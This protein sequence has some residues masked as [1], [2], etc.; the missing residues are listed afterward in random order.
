MDWS[1]TL[2]SV[3]TCFGRFWQ[4]DFN[5]D[6]QPRTGSSSDVNEDALSSLRINEVPARRVY[7]PF[8]NRY[9]KSVSPFKET[10]FRFQTEQVDVTFYD[11]T[12]QAQSCFCGDS[13]CFYTTRRCRSWTQLPQS[14]KNGSSIKFDRDENQLVN[15][16]NP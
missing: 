15:V 5:L 9:L 10:S 8:K 13:L 14:M 6:D 4:A 16:H 1:P 12:E 7:T 2:R 3:R 11:R